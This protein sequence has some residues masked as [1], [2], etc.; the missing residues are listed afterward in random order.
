MIIEPALLMGR[1]SAANDCGRAIQVLEASQL[2]IGVQHELLFF[3]AMLVRDANFVPR[4]ID[5]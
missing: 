1:D 5:G 4:R 3:V 2:F